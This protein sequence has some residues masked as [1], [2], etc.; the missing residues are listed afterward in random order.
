MSNL[1]IVADRE[2]AASISYSIG[3][4]NQIRW[5]QEKGAYSSYECVYYKLP[6]RS[7][8]HSISLRGAFGQLN[9]KLKFYLSVN[10]AIR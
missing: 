10:F 8:F 9:E 4:I 7:K 1:L 2:A 3:K 6:E 5:C